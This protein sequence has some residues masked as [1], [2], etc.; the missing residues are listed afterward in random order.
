MH[1]NMV[2]NA[3]KLVSFLC[4]EHLGLLLSSESIQLY[5]MSHIL[6]INLI[7]SSLLGKSTRKGKYTLSFNANVSNK[8][9]P[10]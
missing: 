7:L 1:V 2:L 8:N 3:D 9:M 10:R 5:F 6:R 4:L